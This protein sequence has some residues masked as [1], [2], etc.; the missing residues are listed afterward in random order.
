MLTPV[1]VF[2]LGDQSRTVSF[3][4]KTDGLGPIPDVPAEPDRYPILVQGLASALRKPVSD[5]DALLLA[6]FA[7][8]VAFD[9]FEFG[10]D[11]RRNFST[12]LAAFNVVHVVILLD[13]GDGV[14]FSIGNSGD[15]D[16]LRRQLGS[17]GST[18][19]GTVGTWPDPPIH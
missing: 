3:A 4:V 13:G 9:H 1:I 5:D 14:A 16:D 2:T 17:S 10:A 8:M 11:A 12:A 19:A 15:I 7:L 6:R 18:Y